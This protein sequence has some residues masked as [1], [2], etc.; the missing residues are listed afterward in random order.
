MVC[1]GENTI[2][3][4]V[5]GRLAEA[6]ALGVA[7]HLDSCEGCR[8]VVARAVVSSVRSAAQSQALLA[9]GATLGRYVIL[10]LVGAGAMGVVYAAWD[11]RLSRKVALK[12]LR[13][14]VETREGSRAGLLGEAQALARL[15]HPHVIAVHDV[16]DMGEQVFLAMEF[17]EG[18]TLGAWLAGSKRRPSE[19]LHAFCAAGEGLAAAHSKGIVHRDFKPDNVLVGSDGRVRVTD[20]G[21]AIAASARDG[22]AGRSGPLPEATIAGTPAYMAPEQMEGKPADARSDQFSF[23]VALWEA[24]H[25]ARPFDG[26]DLKA[27]RAAIDRGELKAGASS[28]RTPAR[29]QRALVRGLRADPDARHA[30]M[31]ALLRELRRPPLLAPAALAAVA[32]V[33][34]IAAA[35]FA[36]RSGGSPCSGAEGAWGEVWSASHRAS[37]QAAFA[38]AD[39]VSGAPIFAHVDQALGS[40]RQS[41]IA[42]RQDACLATRVRGTQSEMLLDRRMLCLDE[43]RREAE[44]LSRIL[45]QATPAVVAHAGGAVDALTPLSRCADARTLLSALPPPA[46]PAAQPALDEARRISARAKA[47][48]DSGD[49]AAALPVCEAAVES[50]R[51]TGYPLAISHALYLLGD[52]QQRSLKLKLD[53][54][55]ESLHAS[56]AAAEEGR[57]DGAAADAFILLSF[58]S[59]F[60]V[61][62]HLAG[63]RWSRYAA[64]ALARMG[65]DD[66]REALRQQRL[67]TLYFNDESRAALARE[68]YL[69][70]QELYTRA[71]ALAQARGIEAGLAT[72]EFNLGNVDEA[73]RLFHRQLDHVEQVYG[74]NHPFVA[75]ALNNL[76]SALT[77]VGRPAEAIALHRRAR[78]IHRLHGEPD[79]FTAKKL[80]SALHDT[81]QLDEALELARE[82][83]SLYEQTRSGDDAWAIEPLTGLGEDLLALKR[84]GE[85]LVPLE[86]AYR[87][88]QDGTEL[89][90]HLQF[91]L[92]QALWDSGQE[93]ARAATLARSAQDTFRQL[94]GRH[95][96]YY[97]RYLGEADAWISAHQAGQAQ[98]Q[99]APHQVQ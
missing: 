50:A 63:E 12:L 11:P 77:D 42:M 72:V 75:M 37:A 88:H 99:L 28:R 22:E 91:A 97:R 95:G 58:V 67:G 23:C 53:E 33:L 45:E 36:L 26:A 70:A 61:P 86:R 27:L 20:F 10:E 19:I 80:A 57:D 52:A 15:A 85:A 73:L 96:S 25:G 6:I 98:L 64:A 24:L 40:L 1:F 29:L 21:L 93:Q 4:F 90:A 13:G 84:P 47:L 56:A 74:P 54:A 79:Y 3:D 71:G 55:E 69:K 2:A 60:R 5:E 68:H 44:A 87:Q 35:G 46:E 34:A 43:R 59:G 38:A 94:A 66:L 65:G 30:S 49:Y 17:V 7:G 76:G 48:I 41:W 81:G 62:D 31:D 89:T 18:E 16:G 78:E 92:A 9:R 39:A 14:D 8:E 32:L 51:R 83:V 82:S